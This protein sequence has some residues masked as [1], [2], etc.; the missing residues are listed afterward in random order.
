MGHGAA[1]DAALIVA[2]V[3]LYGQFGTGDI[4]TILSG[5]RRRQRA[6]A[7]WVAARWRWPRS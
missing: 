3:V 2:V 5:R 1:G 4:A 6:G 7:T